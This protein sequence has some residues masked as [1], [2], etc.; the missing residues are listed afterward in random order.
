MEPR[1]KDPRRNEE[2][3]LDLTHHEAVKNVTQERKDEERFN[4]LLRTIFYIC[5]LAGF[6]IKNRII[7]EDKQTGREWR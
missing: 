6:R 1:Y 4:K 5:D 2:G 3:Y 7:F